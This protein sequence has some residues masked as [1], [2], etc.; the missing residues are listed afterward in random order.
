MKLNYFCYSL[1]VLTLAASLLV[2]HSLPAWLLMVNLLTLLIYGAD[3]HA[4]RKSW[5]RVPER[6]LLVYGLVGGWVGA[7]LAQQLFRHKT[8]KQP[9]KTWFMASVMLN[10]VAVV[11]ICYWKATTV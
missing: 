6:T 3:K 9:F 11:G 1:L 8:Q 7:L 5:Q 4:A 10:V 2:F